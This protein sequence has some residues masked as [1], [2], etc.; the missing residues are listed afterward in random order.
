MPEIMVSELYNHDYL[1]KA[2]I[3]NKVAMAGAWLEPWPED[4][5]FNFQSRVAG[6]IP[7]LVGVCAGGKQ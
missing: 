6:S 3:K 7:A 2:L 4:L 1:V 5:G